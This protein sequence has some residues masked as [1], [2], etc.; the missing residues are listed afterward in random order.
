MCVFILLGFDIKKKFDTKN[1]SIIKR[2]SRNIY[3]MFTY[4][5]SHTFIAIVTCFNQSGYFG[6]T[7]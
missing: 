5:F 7:G 2:Y 6:K 1:D 4:K 3:L